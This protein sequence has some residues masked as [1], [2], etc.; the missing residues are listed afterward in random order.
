M[1]LMLSSLVNSNH[2]KLINLDIPDPLNLQILRVQSIITFPHNF[3]P[4]IHPLKSTCSNTA[5]FLYTPS[6]DTMHPDFS[7]AL[8]LLCIRRSS[9]DLNS[10]LLLFSEK[11]VCSIQQASRVGFVL[12]WRGR[13]IRESVTTGSVPSRP[14]NTPQPGTLNN[15]PL[16][17]I[18]P[19]MHSD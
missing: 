7:L 17:E 3:H 18:T 13:N 5:N 19:Q 1:D 9:P 2:Q 12:N 15:F 6:Q 11:V 16:D 14:P 8:S 10:S 4:C